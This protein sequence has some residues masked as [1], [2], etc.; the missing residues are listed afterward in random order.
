MLA[1][2]SPSRKK[3]RKKDSPS[4]DNHPPSIGGILSWGRRRRERVKSWGDA[5]FAREATAG[6]ERREEVVS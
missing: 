5:S 4:L 6:M 2:P 3:S 1:D